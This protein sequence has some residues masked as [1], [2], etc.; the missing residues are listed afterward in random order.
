MTFLRTIAR[1]YW[2]LL[3]A[4]VV[5]GIAWIAYNLTLVRRV[6]CSTRVVALSYDD[7]PNGDS[8]VPLLETLEKYHV[9]ATFFLLG[10]NLEER[11]DLG[12]KIVSAGHEVG[13][14]GY[15]HASMDRQWPTSVR[16]E[17]LKT[18]LLLAGLNAKSPFLFRAPGFARSPWLQLT[19]ASMWRRNYLAD[20]DPRDWESEDAASVV[21]RVVSQIRPGSIIVLHDGGKAF[22]KTVSEGIIL[23]LLEKRF[24]FKTISELLNCEES[25]RVGN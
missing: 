13:N 3:A 5:L 10:Q 7:G 23:A 16:D 20:V 24:Q 21:K 2:T 22:S 4:I 15:T 17:I 18:D 14:H 19:L 12:R 6:G 8:T 1:P 11:L 9:R 25:D